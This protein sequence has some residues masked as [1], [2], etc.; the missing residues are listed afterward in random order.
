LIV[1][2]RLEGGCLLGLC[3]ALGFLLG[4]R[5]VFDEDGVASRTNS[6]SGHALTVIYAARRMLAQTSGRRHSRDGVSRG[7]VCS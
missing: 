6:S 7:G 3:G 4:W 5:C 2:A 1:A